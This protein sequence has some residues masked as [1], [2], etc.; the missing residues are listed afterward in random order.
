M[1]NNNYQ[2]E[3]YDENF[4]LFYNKYLTNQAKRYGN[5]IMSLLNKRGLQTGKIIDIMCGTG[6]LL[7][8]FENRG[9]ETCGVD[10]SESMLEVAKTNL[11]KTKLIQSDII[12]FNSIDNY[13]VAVAT[14]DALNH[15]ET[16]EDVKGVFETVFSLLSNS[17]YFIF[18]MNT[19][20]GIKNNNY[21]ISSSD[22]D[23][24]SI[25]EGFVDEIHGVGFTR[26]YGAFKT[27]KH[28][29]YLRFDSTIYNY[30]H[31]IE[32]LE[33]MLL[34]IGFKT[35]EIRDGY[36]ELPWDFDNTERVL[37]ICTK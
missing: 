24:I 15:L 6:N 12:K 21:Y 26:F 34:E 3:N 9:W 33:K 20:L 22:E 30:F 2:K 32:E 36:S 23:G 10:I 31:D 19:P 5:F 28:S 35:V 17:G 1:S 8:Q 18:D 16:K 29:P 27:D 13:Q 37:F 25:R 4:S 14:A 11:S 7:V